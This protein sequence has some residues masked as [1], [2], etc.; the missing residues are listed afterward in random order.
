MTITP[1]SAEQVAESM[2]RIEFLVNEANLPEYRASLRIINAALS[3][4][5]DHIVDANK[6]MQQAAPGA[7][8]DLSWADYEKIRD[9]LDV[10]A[11]IQ[12]FHENATA[13]NATEIV[14]AVYENSRNWASQPHPTGDT[15][16]PACETCHGQ[17]VVSFENLEGGTDAGP[18]P[19]CGDTQQEAV[20]TVTA[21]V[22][23]Q[24]SM[25]CGTGN[26]EYAEFY[27]SEVISDRELPLRTKVFTH[28]PEATALAQQVKDK[29]VEICE[30]LSC[31]EYA[32]A[33]AC[34]EIAS[35]PI[36]EPRPDALVAM[37]YRKAAGSLKNLMQR[38]IKAHDV[39]QA[40][41][42]VRNRD[43]ARE[44]TAWPEWAEQDILSLTPPAAQAALEELGV[45][46][47]K[48]GDVNRLADRFRTDDELL[49][50]ARATLNQQN[51]KD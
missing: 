39:W 50:L 44:I 20:G 3:Q 15:Q 14:K 17:K 37:A 2:K 51:G 18:C 31:G 5:A 12:N 4:Q 49:T 26:S 42:D 43:A 24:E 25:E 46:L 9:F 32:V 33:A 19:N 13:D 29:A 8:G 41:C 28:P 10:D 16:K 27:R 45:R 40:M 30:R 34:K 47:V 21:S 38:W 23:V 7:A 6:M 1:Y 11:A 35:I 22:F 36:P 48:A